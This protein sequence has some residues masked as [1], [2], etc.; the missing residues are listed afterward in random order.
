MSEAIQPLPPFVPG[1]ERASRQRGNALDVWLA[2]GYGQWRITL[3]AGSK[4]LTAVS[5]R[6]LG[7]A[8]DAAGEAAAHVASMDAAALAAHTTTLR[9][10]LQ[11]HGLTD[12]NSAQAL[13]LACV[14][15][16]RELGLVP[17]RVQRMGAAALLR[18]MVAEMATG[19][20]KSLTAALAA[21]C[22][23]LS[24]RPV[25]IITVNDYLA[26]RDAMVH[27]PLSAALGLHVAAVQAAQTPPQRVQVYAQDIVYCTNKDVVFDYMRD[28][29]G[30]AGSHTP[31]QA[32]VQSALGLSQD[33]GRPRAL[34]ELAFAIVDEA[35]SVLIDEARTPLII[36]SERDRVPL[37]VCREALDI[38]LALD[39]DEHFSVDRL[40]HQVAL[41]DAGVERTQQLAAALHGL[42]RSE[43]ARSHLVRQALS[44]TALFIRERD[45]I[46][47]DGKVHIV[48]EF[49]GRVLPDRAWEQGIHQMIELK[50]GLAMTP[51]REPVAR[52]TYPAYFTRY[53]RLAGMTG[54]AREVAGE[55]WALY[56]LKVACIPT[57]RPVQRVELPAQV[58]V[59]QALQATAL[60]QA[61]RDMQALGRAVLI[62]T[63]SVQGSEH[64]AQALAAQGIAH[65]VLNAK[66][67]A[68]EAGVVARAGGPG[69]VT[70]A[71][72]MAGRG[73]DI[74]L[75]AATH[76]AGGLHVILTEF[77]E[78]GRIDRQLVGRCAR[79]GDPGSWQA[80]THVR[81]E[82]FQRYAPRWSALALRLAG[83]RPAL[84]ALLASLLRQGAQRRAERMNAW[85]R[86]MAL[87]S[88]RRQDRL[89]AFAG[90]KS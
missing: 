29:L 77:H 90:K 32:A 3:L 20:G 15:A 49:T 28:H 26:E 39:A 57:H 46:V 74:A 61:C 50:E 22:V 14:L 82:I 56:G 67:D 34:R 9:Q 89:M 38:A 31:R 18:G 23:A 86:A 51:S 2:R 69:C 45:Y 71:T 43:R 72:N 76:A 7:A 75:A 1:I 65:V 35:D 19:E 59:S 25:H 62:G 40:H 30:Q 83:A 53:A 24:G 48:D 6:A 88:E 68:D 44:A 4:A 13:G 10:A 58:F 87:R 79:Q 33:G 17:H 84:P 42:W 21:A 85:T 37:Q 81:A 63:R 12:A 60:V 5:L 80:I 11:R 27:R 70:V 64:V 73:T 8:A 47:R 52:L 66:Q 41:T 36:S 54:T 16:Q 78:S 55:L